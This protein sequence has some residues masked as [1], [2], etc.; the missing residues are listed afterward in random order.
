[1]ENELEDS[2]DFAAKKGPFATQREAIKHASKMNVADIL[3]I[4][5]YLN[6]IE[7]YPLL[8][9]EEE[10][11]LFQLYKN[12]NEKAF[13]KIIQS[14]LRFVIFVAKKYIWQWVPLAD[15]IQEWNI[16]LIEAARKFDHT[17]WFKFTSYAV[18]N[19]ISKILDTISKANS[20]L[21]EV[22][23]GS[24]NK[25]DSI[26]YNFLQ[27][28]WRPPVYRELKELCEDN[29]IKENFI[30]YYDNKKY[31]LLSIPLNHTSVEYKEMWIDPKL[32]NDI[33]NDSIPFN[34]YDDMLP[35]ENENQVT[36]NLN[37]EDIKKIIEILLNKVT[38]YE[39]E[40]I[41]MYYWIWWYKAMSLEEIWC[42]FWLTRE[43]IRQI[44][45]KWLKRL[46]NFIKYRPYMYEYIINSI[47]VDLWVYKD[48]DEENEKLK[49][50]KE[51]LLT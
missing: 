50:L 48:E 32:L 7:N 30:I 44:R 2:L 8:K 6:D 40:V 36:E 27:E 35:D 45:E 39:S 37:Y 20:G 15:L 10:A 49:K 33:F 43:R 11:Y 9:P 47:N 1:M 41:K 13:E 28:N 25:V 38:P 31:N 21:T 29:W 42:K 5:D 18:Y 34:S 17:R 24:Y 14:N 4:K 51:L 23:K 22:P 26:V 3:Y 16:W 19:I 12:W 46:K